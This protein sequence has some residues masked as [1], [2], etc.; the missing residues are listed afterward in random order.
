MGDLLSGFPR[1]PCARPLQGRPEESGRTR[2]G[3]QLRPADGSEGT[4]RALVSEETPFADTNEPIYKANGLIYKENELIYLTLLTKVHLVKALIFPIVMYGYKTWTIK[5]AVAATA[6]SLQSCPTLCNP[7]DSSP[8]GSPAPG[9]LQA[10]TLE[11]VA[12]SFSNA[13]K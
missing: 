10:R 6:K 2:Q 11:W 13:W 5:K 9:I 1:G 7:I 4:G 3:A 12:I 8:S